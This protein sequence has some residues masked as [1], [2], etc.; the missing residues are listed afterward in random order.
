MGNIGNAGMRT[1][2]I[3]SE[4]K[5]PNES[6]GMHKKEGNVLLMPEEGGKGKAKKG[7]GCRIREAKYYSGNA[8][9]IRGKIEKSTKSNIASTKATLQAKMG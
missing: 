1:G 3:K 2:N 4:N 7:I 8:S 5:R 6:N 9:I